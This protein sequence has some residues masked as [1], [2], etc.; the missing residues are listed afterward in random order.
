MQ[1][2]TALI[3]W[4]IIALWLAV[5]STVARAYVRNPKIFGVTRLLLIV[6]SIDTTRNIIENLYFGLYFGSQYKLFSSSIADVLGSPY[7]LIVPKLINV[8]AAC[9]VLALLLFRWLPLALQERLQAEQAVEAKT[10]QL[11]L[12]ADERRRIIETALDAFMQIDRRGEILQWSSQAEK[13]FGPSQSEA[14]GLRLEDVIGIDAGYKIHLE[15]IV[16]GDEDGVGGIRIQADAKG[17][18]AEGKKADALKIELSISSFE[19][20]GEHVFNIFA[21]DLTEKLA[22]ENQ[23][24]QSQKMQAVGQLTG[25]IAHDFNNILTV[26]TG[27]TDTLSMEV[28]DRSDLVDLTGMIE[29]AANRGADLTRQLLAFARKQPLQPRNLDVNALVA[30]AERLLK[31]TLGERIKIKTNLSGDPWLAFVDH[32][33]LASAILNLSLN[34][35][36]AMPK[37][38]VLTLETHNVSLDDDYAGLHNEVYAGDYVQLSVSDN[39]SGIPP[40]IIDSIFEPFFTTKAA[41]EGTGLGLSMVYGFVKQSRGHIKVYSEEGEGTTFKLYLPRTL[42]ALDKRA[43]KP[44]PAHGGDEIVLVVEDDTLVRSYVVKQVNGLGYR[45]LVAANAEEALATLDKNDVDLLF[46]DVIM[47]GAMNGPELVRKAQDRRPDLR[48]LYTSGYPEN[49]IVHNGRLDAGV[50]LLAKP[51]SRADLAKM[52]RAA[53]DGA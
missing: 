37:G 52:L 5:L 47:P 34:A 13:L 53:L 49:A 8:L 22:A 36:D 7:L 16:H 25:G 33:Q 26:I 18:D 19:R 17:H 35:R 12:E 42:G 20:Q 51:Y 9:V 1:T 15:S 14:I 21:R 43:E 40:G 11:I 10:E 3:Y 4:V 6:V 45:T 27:A 38:G 50:L 28:T 24:R 41:G 39:G 46:T 32:A 31:P 48:V 29:E 23:L 2:A 44:A 30:D